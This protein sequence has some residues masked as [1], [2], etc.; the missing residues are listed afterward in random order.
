MSS[1]RSIEG[2]TSISDGSTPAYLSRTAISGARVPEQT[3]RRT[4]PARSSKS[5]S[6]IQETSRPSAIRSLSAIQRSSPGGAAPVGLEA[7]RA[8]HL[9]RAGGVLDEQD[10]DGLA[11]DRDRLDTPEHGLDPRQRRRGRLEPDPE[12]ERG[13]ER[14]ERV[15]DV[16]EAGQRKVE[17]DLALRGR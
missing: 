16:V 14:G 12:P 6:Q 17:L 8:E 1:E 3:T 13:G 9:V 4:A 2:S 11:A 5:A 7:Q 15:V 10:R